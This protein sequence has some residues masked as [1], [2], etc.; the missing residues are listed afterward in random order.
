MES[1]IQKKIE[2]KGLIIS[3]MPNWAKVLIINRAKE[4]FC[5][6]YGMCMSAIL[7]ESLEYNQLKQMFFENELNI[8]MSFDKEPLEE[9][10]KNEQKIKFANGKKLN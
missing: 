6:D 3:R 8:K 5:D 4:E 10:E 2:Q 9:D 7:K 1:D